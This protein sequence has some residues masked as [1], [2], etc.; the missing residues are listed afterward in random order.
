[1][2]DDLRLL[3]AWERGY[4]QA[5]Y[6]Q[7]LILIAARFADLSAD[8][9]LDMP[10]GQRDRKLMQIRRELFGNRLAAVIHCPSCA[11]TLEVNLDLD[12]LQA[13][14]TAQMVAA[15]TL[16]DC[17]VQ[18]RLPAVGDLIAIE[19]APAACRAAQ[20]LDRCIVEIRR[21][22]ELVHKE[23]LHPDERERMASAISDADPLADIRLALDCLEC[24]H[25][26]LAPFDIVSI[27][28]SELNAACQR[29]MAEIHVL[30][31]AYGW[32]ESEILSLS[33]WR[34]QIYLSMVRQ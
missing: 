31:Q 27:L 20:L 7:A 9:L 1:M 19:D 11:E 15:L 13:G 10:I 26:W 24:R 6:R 8:S 23:V 29:L 16:S 17:Q 21:E 18:L 5:P 14:N 12:Q 28:W 4:S 32:P 30:A 34:R 22:Q 3:D 2:L 25:N 33:P